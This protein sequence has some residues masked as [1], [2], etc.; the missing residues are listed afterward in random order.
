MLCLGKIWTCIYKIKE[1]LNEVLWLGLYCLPSLK[2]FFILENKN[3]GLKIIY[4]E[5]VDPK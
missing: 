4:P 5:K 1:K 2:M 3:L